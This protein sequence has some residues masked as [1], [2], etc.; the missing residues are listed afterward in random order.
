M[1]KLDIILLIILAY[2]GVKG[3]KIGFIVS[4][5][6]FLF[7]FIGLFLALKFTVPV[8]EWLFKN[9]NFFEV[10]SIIIFFILFILLNLGVTLVI[11]FLKKIIDTTFM[12]ILDNL[13]GAVAGVFKW[14][15][16]LTFIAW[17]LELMGVE[18]SKY[19]SDTIVFSYVLILGSETF[20]WLSAIFPSISDLIESFENIAKKKNRLI[21]EI[22]YRFDFLKKNL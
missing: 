2:G 8:A 4:F 5:F 12:G 15:F 1:S 17:G 19:T 9:S 14:V 11:T 6:S 22:V 16:I 7:F 21:T 3:Y 20:Y 10:I 13:L 18:I